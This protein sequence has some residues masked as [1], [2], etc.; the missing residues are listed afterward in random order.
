MKNL[1]LLAA[2][3]AAADINI[4]WTYNMPPNVVTV[5][6]GDVVTFTY[7]KAFHDV[8]LMGSQAAYARAPCPAAP[9]DAAHES[10]LPPRRTRAR[11]SAGASFRTRSWLRRNSEPAR[12]TSRAA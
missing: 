6:T 5:G 4:V 10:D 3:A 1:L 12:S 7:N 9:R 2:G 8:T 11:S